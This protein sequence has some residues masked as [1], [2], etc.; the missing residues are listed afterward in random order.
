VNWQTK[1]M[2]KAARMH[3]E[4]AR[5]RLPTTGRPL[6]GCAGLQLLAAPRRATLQPARTRRG[7]SLDGNDVESCQDARQT[8]PIPIAHTREATHQVC[9]AAAAGSVPQAHPAAAEP[10]AV[11]RPVMSMSTAARMHKRQVQCRL[12][13]TRRLL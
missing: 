3:K 11:I 2:L 6:T 1:T 10:A 13:T 9:R 7:D 12:P 8:E 4:Q 5:S